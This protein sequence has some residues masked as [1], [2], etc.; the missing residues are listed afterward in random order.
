MKMDNYYAI[1]SKS[2]KGEWII[3]YDGLGLRAKSIY[4]TESFAEDRME[5][6]KKSW[7]GELYVLVEFEAPAL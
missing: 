2:G 4:L 7:P 5:V 6:M 3:V 1:L